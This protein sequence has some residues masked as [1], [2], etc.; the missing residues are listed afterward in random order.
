MKRTKESSIKVESNNV[1]AGDLFIS[2][3]L[4]NEK[5]PSLELI[6]QPYFLKSYMVNQTNIQLESSHYL[7]IYLKS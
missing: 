1:K 3:S 4:C 5:N 7:F 6:F 2:I